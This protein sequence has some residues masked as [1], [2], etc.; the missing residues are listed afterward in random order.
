MEQSTGLHIGK[1]EYKAVQI[2]G[3]LKL[4]NSGGNLFERINE[5]L[6]NISPVKTKEKVAFFRLLATM[7]NAGVSLVK[8]LHILEDQTEDP[9]LKKICGVLAQGVETG[10]SLSNGMASFPDIFPSAPLR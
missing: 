9:K 6:I 2:G 4:E 5:W 10:Q 3:R 7:I 8:S 1:D